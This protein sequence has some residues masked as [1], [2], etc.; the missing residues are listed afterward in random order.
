MG[1]KIN[2]INA[3]HLQLLKKYPIKI[4]N[5][6]QTLLKP[7]TDEM[8]AGLD[9][10]IYE[11]GP[12]LSEMTTKLY[13]R[14]LILLQTNVLG[15]N[16]SNKEKSNKDDDD[17]VEDVFSFDV[18]LLENLYTNYKHMEGLHNQL[19]VIFI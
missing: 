18:T 13:P 5:P 14:H 4:T 9:E 17:S 12:A 16:L 10:L 1:R 3:K 2:D 6:V 8:N 15:I 7:W 19:L 11:D